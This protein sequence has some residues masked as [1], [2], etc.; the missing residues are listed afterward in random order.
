M[1]PNLAGGWGN[2]MKSDTGLNSMKSGAPSQQLN[3]PLRHRD[4]LGNL[5]PFNTPVP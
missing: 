1:T 4:W 3:T 5:H 2:E